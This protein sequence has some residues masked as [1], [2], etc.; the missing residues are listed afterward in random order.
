[1]NLSVLRSDKIYRKIVSANE[2]ERDDIYRYEL[3]K[4][5]E[6]KW[7]CIGMPLKTAEPEGYDVVSAASMNGGY[8]PSKMT[9]SLL[10]VIEQLATA[11]LWSECEQSIRSTL[12]GFLSNGIQLKV[13]DYL[14]TLLL[15]DPQNPMSHFT[16]DCCGDG[17]ISGYL[18]GTIIPNESSMKKMPVVMAHETNH[19]V[20][21]QYVKWSQ[22]TTL[23][24]LVVSEG[25]A[26]NY[27]VYRYGKDMLGIWATSM[28]E[29]EVREQV[30]P[31]IYEHLQETNFQKI[32][33]Y[34]YGDGIMQLRGAVPIGVPD[35]AGYS[36]GYYLIQHYLKKTGVD[37]YH[38]TITP[39]AEILNEVTDFWR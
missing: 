2:T 34:L 24:D 4:P 19:N 32:S 28:T 17:G 14:F 8:A 29:K 37:I 30:N 9:Q 26:E 5:F 21:W 18:I 25:L 27:E 7:S 6:F 16:G 31:I 15:N 20:R 1:M 33:S 36:C 22:N 13:Q 23:A 3:M 39:T 12:E 35:Y 38:A 10:P 11:S